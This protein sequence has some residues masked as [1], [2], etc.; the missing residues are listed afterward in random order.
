MTLC[1]D[2]GTQLQHLDKDHKA[3]FSKCTKCHRK[4]KEDKKKHVAG[5]GVAGGG[6]VLPQARNT[7]DVAADVGF[8]EELAV[9]SP[10][11]KKNLIGTKLY[12]LIQKNHPEHAGKIVGMFLEAYHCQVLLTLLRTPDNLDKEIAY[13]LEEIKKRSGTKP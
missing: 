13:A 9:A 2:C 10:E 7:A 5:G 12:G 3:W 8:A 4:Q 1:T 6:V 11:E